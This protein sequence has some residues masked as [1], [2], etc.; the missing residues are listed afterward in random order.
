MPRAK[1]VHSYRPVGE[2]TE[3][4]VRRQE[5]DEMREAASVLASTR[6]HS[7]RRPYAVP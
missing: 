7:L 2:R 4:L 1:C 5:G 3:V 6:S